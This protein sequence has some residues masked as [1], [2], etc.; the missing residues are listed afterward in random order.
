MSSSSDITMRSATADDLTAINAVI[1][2]AI[3]NWDLPERVKRLALPSYR[4]D[5]HDLEHLQFCVAESDHEI[6]GVA[7]IE[8]ADKKELPEKKQGLLLHGLYVHPYYQHRGVGTQLLNRAE[9]QVSQQGLDGLLVRAQSNAGNF[10]TAN[11]MQLLDTKDDR[12]YQYRY[13]KQ[14]A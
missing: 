12:N 13:W 3:M 6:I 10:F 4:Y 9:Q 14:I 7:A 5:Q 8:A 2:A 1:E 11:G